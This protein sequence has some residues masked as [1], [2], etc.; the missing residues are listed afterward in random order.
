MYTVLRGREFIENFLCEFYKQ[1]KRIK[2]FKTLQF[3][4][5]AGAWEV[6][7]WKFCADATFDC[8]RVRKRGEYILK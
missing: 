2:N 5:D 1:E 4:R 6:E 7:L 3:E 8:L